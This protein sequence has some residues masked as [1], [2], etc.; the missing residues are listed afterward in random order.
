M[1][2]CA[3]EASICRSSRNHC[4]LAVH[5]RSSLMRHRLF[6][7]PSSRRARKISPMPPLAATAR[8]ARRR[9]DG[10]SS[11]PANRTSSPLH[12]APASSH[13]ASALLATQNRRGYRKASS[14]RTSASKARSL[15][16][17]VSTKAALPPHPGCQRGFDDF[18]RRATRSPPASSGRPRVSSAVPTS[19]CRPLFVTMRLSPRCR[20]SLCPKAESVNCRN[21]L[22]TRRPAR[23]DRRQ[24]AQQKQSGHGPLALDG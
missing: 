15:A 4:L 19:A 17:E 9:R 3:S 1:H 10:Q 20:S 23:P 21:R 11:A 18:C 7:G 12:R 2:G 22:T 8:F 6:I 13:P 16:Q 14:E 24:L 5:A